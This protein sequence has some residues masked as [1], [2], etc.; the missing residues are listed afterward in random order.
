MD[1]FVNEVEDFGR[2]LTIEFTEREGIITDTQRYSILKLAEL[3]INMS[4][5]A[6]NI[7]KQNEEA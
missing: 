3:C 2:H 6:G 7:K 1:E 5:V 4:K